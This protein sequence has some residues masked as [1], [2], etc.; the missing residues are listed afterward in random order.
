[1]F[2]HRIAIVQAQI[3]REIFAKIGHP[4]IQP[5]IDHP[6]ADH[7]LGEPF[8]S[9]R[10]GEI[11]HACMEFTEIDKIGGVII[12][13][14]REKSVC[15]CF[16]VKRAINRQIGVCIAQKADAP[17]LQRRDAFGQ[18]GISFRVPLPVPEQAAAKAGFAHADPVF[19]P[20]ARYCRARVDQAF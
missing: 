19:A 10:V 17:R 7:L 2:L 8:G 4:P 9:V 16:G 5:E 18:G 6:L 1:M 14:A 11:D 13:L 20:Q 3:D 12:E 15:R